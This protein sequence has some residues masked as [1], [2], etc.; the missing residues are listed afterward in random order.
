[1]LATAVLG[2]AAL[3]FVGGPA[4]GGSLGA[5]AWLFAVLGT[6]LALAQLLLFSGMASAD[7]GAT[8]TVWLAALA[9][10][11]LVELLSWTGRL[12]PVTLVATASVVAALLV[13][14]GLARR[15]HP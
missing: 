8:A 4:Y 5:T 1:V 10:V 11:L 6:L 12:T 15:H 13:G 14:T 3:P 7:R 2:S 9:E